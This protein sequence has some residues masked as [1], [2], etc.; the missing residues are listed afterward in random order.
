[1]SLSHLPR[2]PSEDCRSGPSTIEFDHLTGKPRR[3]NLIIVCRGPGAPTMTREPDATWDWIEICWHPQSE[4]LA[5]DKIIF[6]PN[7]QLR[8]YCS[9]YKHVPAEELRLYESIAILDDDIQVADHPWSEVLACFAS[10]G[11]SVGHP[12]LTRDSWSAW[13]ILWK[14]TTAASMTSPTSPVSLST[15]K[16]MS[17]LW[18]HLFCF[19]E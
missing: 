14:G 15:P 13:P 16:T 12:A 18:R 9:L 11:A 10:T 17:H 19:S 2:L 8:K 3:K 4:R 7:R 6:D 1:M 5:C